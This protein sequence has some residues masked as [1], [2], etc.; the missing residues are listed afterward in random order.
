MGKKKEMAKR[1]ELIIQDTGLDKEEAVSL[2][3]IFTQNVSSDGKIK[4]GSFKRIMRLAHPQVKV[5]D[6]ANHL[7][8]LY[9][10]NGDE[11]ID[12]DEFWIICRKFGPLLAQIL[13]LA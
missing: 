12:F 4:V 2:G 1:I 6:L 10:I 9:D 11:G 3:Q 13:S 8:R 7:F 5:D